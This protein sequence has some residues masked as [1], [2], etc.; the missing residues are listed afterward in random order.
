MEDILKNLNLRFDHAA[1]KPETTAGDIATLCSEARQ[2]ELYA[3]A[4]NPVWVSS[5]KTELAGSDVRIVSV[6]GFPLGASRTDIKISEAVKAVSDGAHEIDVV[7]GIGWLVNGQFTEAER[8]IH[9]IREN[10]PYNVQLKVIIEAGKLSSQQQADAV[11]ACINGGAQ[12]VKT[13]TGF[14]GGATIDQVRNMVQAADK[15][16]EVKASGGIRSLSD[17]RQLLSAGATRLGSS[18]S[19]AIMRELRASIEQD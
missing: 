7:A 12:F 2:Y 10:L 9:E 19:T 11:K 1:L 4:I 8:E 17:C 15:Q 13:S 14:F 18:A 6:A 3:V 16:I 5:A